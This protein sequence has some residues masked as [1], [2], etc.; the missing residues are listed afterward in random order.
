MEDTHRIRRLVFRLAVFAL[1]G[2]AVALV[3]AVHPRRGWD[4]WSDAVETS[5]ATPQVQASVKPEQPAA[6]RRPIRR[7]KLVTSFGLVL[8]FFAAATFTAGAGDLVAK[9]LDPARCAALMQ[10]TGEDETICAQV[11]Q[12]EALD[13]AQSAPPAPELAPESEPLP[14][15]EPSTELS[16]PTEFPQSETEALAA[17]QALAEAEAALDG[18]TAP[19]LLD[20]TATADPAAAAD[21]PLILET[22]TPAAKPA[23]GSSRHWVVR[24]AKEAKAPAIEEEGDATI[25]LNRELGDPTPPAKWLS[26]VFAKNLQRISAVNGVSWALVLGVLRAEGARDRVPATVKELSTLARGLAARGAIDSEWNAAL[27]L[28]GRTGFADRAV[29][30]ARY[31]RVVG[32][33]ALVEGLEAAKPRLIEQLLADERATIYASGRDDLRLG[34]IDVRTIIVIEYLAESF[35]EVTI[36]SLTSGHRRY[37]RPGVVSAHVYGH[38]VD[39]ASVGGISIVGH[40]QEGSITEKAVRSILMLPVEIQ[41]RQVI[42]L[43]G[44]GG[45]SFPMAD[46]DDHIHVGF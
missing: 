37:A 20:P 5:K 46:H 29:A 7:H 11:A 33:K 28:S 18:D 32:L 41:P 6:A 17:E 40:Q 45:A 13:A 1:I 22:D 43:I 39:I 2:W 21:E 19:E 44:M 16:E 10:A 25:W 9:A 15:A 26:P 34:R 31:N 3:R 27:S 12:E 35:G 4:E 30:L 36:S 14:L 23:Q 38:A 8:V 24:R 42:S